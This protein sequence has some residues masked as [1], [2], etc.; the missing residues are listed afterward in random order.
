MQTTNQIQ[1]Y[2]SVRSSHGS[3]YVD[4]RSICHLSA[5]QNLKNQQKG[6]A[7]HDSPTLTRQYENTVPPRG[8]RSSRVAEDRRT[9]R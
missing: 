5:T 3:W 4:L 7:A 1:L 9:V 6:P 2:S 8:R